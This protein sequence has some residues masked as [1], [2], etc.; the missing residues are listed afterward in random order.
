MKK[1]LLP[2]CFFAALLGVTACTQNQQTKADEHAQDAKQDVQKA[3]DEVKTQAKN[4][5]DNVKNGTEK[6]KEKAHESAPDTQQANEKLQAATG[7]AKEF[8]QSA[9]AAAAE[10]V[11]TAKVKTALA[12][13]IGSKTL[14]NVSVE[15]KGTTVILTGKTAS[16]DDRKHAE[17]TALAV[18]GVAHVVNKIQVEPSSGS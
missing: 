2:F 10:S 18:A 12:N 13:D 7:K 3:A 17:Q 14:T 4:L 16:A 15:T 5:A 9:Q 8:G 6:L 11:L 1:S